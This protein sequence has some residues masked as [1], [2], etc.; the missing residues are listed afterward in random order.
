MCKFLLS[1]SNFDHVQNFRVKNKSGIFT[2]KKW[3]LKKK[4][5]YSKFLH[6]VLPSVKTNN[7]KCVR[8]NKKAYYLNK[9]SS[10]KKE[11]ISDENYV[12]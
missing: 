11:K 4:K 1:S 6:H 10:K 9:Q 12:Y 3:I 8:R 2:N 5:C 7:Q